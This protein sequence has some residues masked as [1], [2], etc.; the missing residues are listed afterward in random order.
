MITAVDT[1]VLLDVFSEPTDHSEASAAALRS[2]YDRGGICICPIVYAEVACHFEQRE[3]LDAAL[4]TLGIVVVPD[5]VDTGWHAA[6]SWAG[7]RQVG[8]AREHILPD[9][10]IAAHAVIEAEVLLTRD[11]GFYRKH[12]ADLSVIEP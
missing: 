9:F 8:G 10:F 5:D 2:A 11:R 4:H 3:A 7:Y 6:R 1:N 12:F